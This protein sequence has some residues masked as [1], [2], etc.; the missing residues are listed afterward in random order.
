MSC[1]QAM[2]ELSAAVDGELGPGRAGP[3]EEH[4]AGC[5]ACR[6]FRDRVL[7]LRRQLRF[8]PVGDVPDVAPRVL[9]TIRAGGAAVAPRVQEELGSGG[10]APHRSG[11]AAPHRGGVDNRTT[12]ARRSATLPLRGARQPEPGLGA[13]RRRGVLPVAAAFLGGVV[14]GATFIGLGRGGPG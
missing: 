13:G 12:A 6:A 11:D 2:A 3:L 7:A 10:A 8:E 1:S 14:L 4:V 9:E 5:P